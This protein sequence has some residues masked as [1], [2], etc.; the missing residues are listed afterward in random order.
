MAEA[1]QLP[2]QGLE[3]ANLSVIQGWYPA[4]AINANKS[5][6]GKREHRALLCLVLPGDAGRDSN[7][8]QNY[9]FP[10]TCIQLWHNTATVEEDIRNKK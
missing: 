10:K 8:R 9:G 3:G 7:G 4:P 1:D 6:H 5:R 2:S